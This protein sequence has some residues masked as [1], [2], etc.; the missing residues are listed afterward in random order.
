[1]SAN[2]LSRTS[3]AKKELNR[4]RKSNLLSAREDQ[5]LQPSFFIFFNFRQTLSL[6]M[7]NTQV[8]LSQFLIYVVI[9]TLKD[10]VSSGTRS[11]IGSVIDCFTTLMET[12]E[13]FFMKQ[14]FKR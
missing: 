10:D 7:L 13:L 8:G 2:S 9:P 4:R 6:I 5:T 3:E 1:M 14:Y 11:L 12:C